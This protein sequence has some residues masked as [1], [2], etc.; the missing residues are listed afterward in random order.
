MKVLQS[1]GAVEG[2]SGLLK[3]LFEDAQRALEGGQLGHRPRLLRHPHHHLH[4]NIHIDEYI[5]IY[6][7]ERHSRPETKHYMIQA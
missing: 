2:Q 4:E 6:M 3:N 1:F 5:H 7:N